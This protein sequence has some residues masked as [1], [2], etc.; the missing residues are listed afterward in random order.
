MHILYSE[1][2]GKYVKTGKNW[3][4]EVT[5]I[6]PSVLPTPQILCIVCLAN[7][8]RFLFCGGGGG[9]A[10]RVLFFCHRALNLKTSQFQFRP[11]QN[12]P[13]PKTPKP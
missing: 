10:H 8:H 9:L 5:S 2:Q 4:V 12:S 7:K 3:F 13:K 1:G 6:C 11:T